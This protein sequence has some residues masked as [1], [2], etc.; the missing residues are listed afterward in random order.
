MRIENTS[1]IE[2]M[3]DLER[4]F[5]EEIDDEQALQMLDNQHDAQSTSEQQST[6]AVA[7]IDEDHGS[8]AIPTCSTEESEQAAS[9][10][11]KRQKF[12]S[13]ESE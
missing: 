7:E 10:E 2:K 4:S 8:D 3:A 5:T 9:P 11:E 12:S 6:P 13:T 1:L